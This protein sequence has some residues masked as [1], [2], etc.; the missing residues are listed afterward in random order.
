[1]AGAS[2][3]AD[4]SQRSNSNLDNS[5][6]ASTSGRENGQESKAFSYKAIPST[7]L[8]GQPP[9]QKA[10]RGVAALSNHIP[11]ALMSAVK[12]AD[13]LIKPSGPHAKPGPSSGNWAC[14]LRSQLS[15]IETAA[16]AAWR[17]NGPPQL[18]PWTWGQ[19]QRRIAGPPNPNAAPRSAPPG[20][21]LIEGGR[22][23]DEAPRLVGPRSIDTR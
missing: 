20:G 16:S 8:K 23:L 11:Q 13:E 7:L 18:L 3:Q 14:S 12:R 1:M 4:G 15:Q 10:T 5:L 21:V 17:K 2:G 9:G 22:P 19:N 6:V